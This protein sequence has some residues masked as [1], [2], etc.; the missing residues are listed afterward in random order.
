[1]TGYSE[2]LA[3]GKSRGLTILSKPFRE[4][5]MRAAL[6]AARR[7]VQPSRS[8]VVRLALSGRDVDAR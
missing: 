5:E 7:A 3:T 1:M 8:N 6:R 2:A 4:A